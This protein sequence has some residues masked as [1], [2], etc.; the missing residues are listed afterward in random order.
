MKGEGDQKYP[1]FW[2]R[3]L[4]MTPNEWA[5]FENENV[6]NYNTAVA[7]IVIKSTMDY[8]KKCNLSKSDL[9]FFRLHRYIINQC[10]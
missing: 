6:I 10:M 8:Q 1:K 4:W 9:I 7:V 2:L 3:G 5:S